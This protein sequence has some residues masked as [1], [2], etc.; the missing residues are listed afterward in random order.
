MPLSNCFFLSVKNKQ[1]PC[2]SNKKKEI[3]DRT[4]G[5]YDNTEI[6]TIRPK[7]R[8]DMKG[9][10][11][12]RWELYKKFDRKNSPTQKV[13]AEQKLDWFNYLLRNRLLQ[14]IQI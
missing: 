2:P 8:G 12:N 13:T 5:S 14:S 4:T 9:K 7:W 10:N 6:T 11:E 1:N 3:F